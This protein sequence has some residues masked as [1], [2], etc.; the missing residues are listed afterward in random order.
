MPPRGERVARLARLHGRPREVALA[1]IEHWSLLEEEIAPRLGIRPGTFTTHKRRAFAVL[2]VSD[3][4]ELYVYYH[5]LFQDCEC[6][7]IPGDELDR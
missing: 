1:L 2:G 4:F 7:F 6:Q 3:R 5:A